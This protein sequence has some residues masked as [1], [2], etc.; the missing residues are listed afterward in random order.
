MPG[1]PAEQ[2]SSPQQDWYLLPAAGS[3]GGKKGSAFK[4]PLK[5]QLRALGH[6]HRPGLSSLEGAGQQIFLLEATV[7][8]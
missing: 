1:L 7:T 6:G 4:K 3:I 5:L 8:F 2:C